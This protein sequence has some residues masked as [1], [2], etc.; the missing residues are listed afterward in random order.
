MSMEFSGRYDCEVQ[1]A[2]TGH[3]ES[4]SSEVLLEIYGKA[5]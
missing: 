3:S 5:S 4:S 1:S 2:G